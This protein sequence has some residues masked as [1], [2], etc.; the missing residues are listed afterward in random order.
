M[1]RVAVIG[2]GH[3]GRN[4]V[5]FLRSMKEVRLVLLVDLDLEKARTVG[6]EVG[7]ATAQSFQDHLKEFDA[8]VLAVPTS[9]HFQIASHL[10]KAGKHLLIEKPVAATLEEAEGLKDLAQETGVIAHVGLPERYSPIVQKVLSE[11]TRPLFIETH[12]LGVFSPRSLDIDVVLDL[13]IHDLDLLYLFLKEEPSQLEAVGIPVLSKNI[14]IA[15]A[16]LKFPGKCVVNLTASRVSAQRMRKMRLFQPYSYIS[17]DFAQQS[18]SSFSLRPDL[19]NAGFPEIQRREFSPEQ[20]HQPLE[21]E[22]ETFRDA[23]LRGSPGGV[24]IQESIPSLKMALA[25]KESF[26]AVDL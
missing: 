9:D 15:N 26:A 12:R 1:L 16:R 11:I 13:M 24:S 5:R 7:T 18:F 6:E 25:I 8:A 20:Q 2:I 23:I 14:D 4:H 19:C 17:L 21:A 3:Q 10:M 22:L